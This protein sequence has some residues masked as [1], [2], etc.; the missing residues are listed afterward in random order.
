MQYFTSGCTRI[1]SILVLLYYLRLVIE[2]NAAWDF[3]RV[4]IDKSAKG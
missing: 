1:V 4:A 2:L 3:E